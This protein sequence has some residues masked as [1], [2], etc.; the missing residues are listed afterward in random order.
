MLIIGM[1]ALFGVVS[2]LSAHIEPDER[3]TEHDDHMK[4]DSA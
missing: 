1:A 3:K 2:W 4:G